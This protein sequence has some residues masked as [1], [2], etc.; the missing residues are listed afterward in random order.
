MRIVA[1]EDSFKIEERVS[2]LKFLYHDWFGFR[3]SVNTASL[4]SDNGNKTHEFTYK[5]CYLTLSKNILSLKDHKGFIWKVKIQFFELKE[6]EKASVITFI[7]QY[8]QKF[9]LKSAK[10]KG[11][12]VSIFEF[13][14]F[15]T[16]SVTLTLN[17][18][19]FH[20]K[21]FGYFRTNGKKLKPNSKEVLLSALDGAE[22]V[23]NNDSFSL[24]RI[25]FENEIKKDADKILN[26][27]EEYNSSPLSWIYSKTSNISGDM[28][29]SGKYHIYRNALNETG[30]KLLKLFDDS[31]DKL[32]EQGD[33]KKDYANS[34]KKNIREYIKGIG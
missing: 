27:I 12:P 20:E 6:G 16:R 8:D 18:T 7:D 15:G 29:E 13:S 11:F 4:Y 17:S 9:S 25:H 22:N 2:P 28:V 23:L 30:Q 19:A 24:V 5:D 33:I 34:Q 14:P 21:V 1:P 26:W 31:T 32:Y 10:W 3:C